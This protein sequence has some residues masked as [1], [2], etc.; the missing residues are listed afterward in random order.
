[1]EICQ[2]IH[3]DCLDKMKYI[4]NKSIDMILADLPYG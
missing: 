1:M 4:P 3:G 2:L